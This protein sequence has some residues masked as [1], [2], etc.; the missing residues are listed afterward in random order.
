[1][2]EGVGASWETPV[3]RVASRSSRLF[4]EIFGAMGLCGVVPT[5]CLCRPRLSRTAATSVVV[6]G[7]IGLVRETE[8]IP[9]AR[10]ARN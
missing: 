6:G 8:S 7:Q 10:L 4:G 5:C 9:L 3:V 2:L 1:M